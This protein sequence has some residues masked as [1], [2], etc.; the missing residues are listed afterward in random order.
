MLLAGPELGPCLLVEKTVSS[1]HA[2]IFH[3]GLLDMLHSSEIE[4]TDAGSDKPAPSNVQ[5]VADGLLEPA[6]AGGVSSGE[7]SLRV[8]I[9]LHTRSAAIVALLCLL[10]DLH[11]AVAAGMHPPPTYSDLRVQLTPP[12][13]SL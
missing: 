10:D 13:L 8:D 6:C 1:N 2:D 9:R 4:V 3:C 12:A 7:A 11:A 5:V